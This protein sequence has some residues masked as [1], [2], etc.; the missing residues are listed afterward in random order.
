MNINWDV[1]MSSGLATT[2]VGGI[3]YLINRAFMKRDNQALTRKQLADEIIKIVTEG[4]RGGLRIKARDNEHLDYIKNQL[5]G[6]DKE[7]G[8]N[9][10]RYILAWAMC[11]M[12]MPAFKLDTI[13]LF[14]ADGE[15]LS[16]LLLATAH[17]WIK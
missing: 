8:E 6:W 13:K 17:K 14:Q 3:G 12:E 7:V 2:L 10:H 11:T 4:D 5:M 9:F 15:R 1:F 16:K